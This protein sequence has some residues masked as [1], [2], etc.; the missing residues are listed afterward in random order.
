[1]INK[2]LMS[3]NSSEWGTPQDFFDKLDREF[4]FTLDACAS[5]TNFKVPYYFHK[6]YDGLRQVWDGNV[7]MNP[8]YGREIGK[9]LRK[10]YYESLF[11]ANVVVCLVP[12]RTDTAWWHN[13]CMKGE[14]RFIKGRLRFSGQKNS[15]PFPSAV[16]IFNKKAGPNADVHPY[17]VPCPECDGSPGHL[18]GCSR[19]KGY[20]SLH[21]YAPERI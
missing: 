11:H 14:I 17:G 8:P 5:G 20:T 21:H 15:A 16:I 10:A 4:H 6:G 7:W 13:Y 9:W 19:D 12:A 3:S 1:M 18:K 2:G